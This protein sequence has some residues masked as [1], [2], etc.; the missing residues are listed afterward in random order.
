MYQNRSLGKKSGNPRF[1]L[2]LGAFI[3]FWVAMPFLVQLGT[4]TAHADHGVMPSL[5]AQLTGS[6]ITDVT[7]RGFAYY[8]VNAA[9]TPDPVRM[10]FVGVSNM[11]LPDGTQLSV[12]LNSTAIGT[13]T[14][15][16]DAVSNGEGGHGYLRLS[17]SNGD[18]VPEVMAGDTLTVGPAPAIGSSSYLS[19]TFATPPTPSPTSTHTPF[20]SPSHTPHPSFTPSPSPSGTPVAPRAF[21]ARMNGANEVPA[22]T[23][24][25]MGHGFVALN[26]AE[27]QIRVCV[28]YRNLS[29]DVT[30][31]TINGPAATTENGPV[32]FTL[33]LPTSLAGFSSQTFDVTADQVAQLRGG[34]WYF[35]VAT[36]NNPDGEIRGQLN[37]LTPR[38]GGSG[39]HQHGGGGG[40]SIVATDDAEYTAA[41]SRS[42]YVRVPFDFDGDGITDIA[43]S[44]GNNWLITRSSDGQ[45]V[46]YR[47]N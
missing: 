18:T 28:G 34:M 23:T 11:N 33:T 26:A 20:P 7:P 13:I 17:T 36:T 21:G 24:D 40:G 27:T 14:L 25:G 41:E 1:L 29:S 9:A 10:L 43:R 46:T 15:D 32:I 47:T 45:T 4:N 42:S 16:N 38:G 39:G 35:Q 37:P 22:V 2:F 6:P 19:G 3:A 12:S 8:V 5:T 44:L 31:I 30:A